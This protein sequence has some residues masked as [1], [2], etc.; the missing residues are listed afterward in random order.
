[1][2][3]ILVFAAAVAIIFLLLTMYLV[4]FPSPSRVTPLDDMESELDEDW[5]FSVD[6]MVENPVNLTIRDLINLPSK[7]VE[8]EL[9]C[10]RNPDTPV[11]RGTWTGV[12]LREIL[13]IANPPS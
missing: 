10:V 9:Y 11:T 7:S 8:A 4:M 13:E 5:S 3:R 6:G 2:K 1:M 12:A